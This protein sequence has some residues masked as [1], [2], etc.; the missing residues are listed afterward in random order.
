MQKI[1]NSPPLG[2]SCGI[3]GLSS[4]HG[5]LIDKVR[6][7]FWELLNSFSDFCVFFPSLYKSPQDGERIF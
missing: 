3:F 6:S 1:I 4:I 2:S 7:S 5:S